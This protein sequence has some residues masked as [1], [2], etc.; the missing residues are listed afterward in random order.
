M[1]SI[2]NCPHSNDLEWD[3]YRTGFQSEISASVREST[4]L[5]IMTCVRP[6]KRPQQ[7]HSKLLTAYLN[8]Y[9]GKHETRTEIGKIAEN[10]CQALFSV[11]S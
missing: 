8:G 7:A 9:N 4:T 11:F 10:P 5:K 1:S 3:H 6:S 2:F